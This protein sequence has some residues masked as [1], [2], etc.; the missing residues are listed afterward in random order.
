MEVEESEI[1][2][3]RP[4]GDLFHTFCKSLNRTPCPYNYMHV[5][6]LGATEGSLLFGSHL[7]MILQPAPFNLNH[8][9]ETSLQPAGLCAPPIPW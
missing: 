5:D 7:G 6:S 3:Y 1:M 4:H 2:P 8:M 9:P